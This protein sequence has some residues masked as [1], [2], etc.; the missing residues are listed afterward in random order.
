MCHGDEEFT[1]AS[2]SFA[3]LKPSPPLLLFL[4]FAIALVALGVAELALE[5]RIKLSRNW[6]LDLGV[7]V[8]VGWDTDGQRARDLDQK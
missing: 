3:G 8:E 5:E 2:C 4:P 7:E 6:E 1:F